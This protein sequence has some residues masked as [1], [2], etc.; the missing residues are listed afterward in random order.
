MSNVPPLNGVP[1]H[2]LRAF[3]CPECGDECFQILSGTVKFVFDC[4]NPGE[5]GAKPINLVACLGCGGYLIKNATGGFMI[6]HKGVED[7]GE[8][9]TWKSGDRTP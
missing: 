8:G 4:L 6:V 1:R 9:E 3:K 7:A 5:M 2:Q